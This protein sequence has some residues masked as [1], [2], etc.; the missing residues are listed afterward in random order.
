MEENNH[1][2]MEQYIK[3]RILEIPQ[4]E[5]RV[6]YKE[7]VGKLLL[8][9]YQYN[10]DSYN[11]LEERVLSESSS[12]QNN[13]AVY[14]TMTDQEHYDA[15]DT[16]MYPMSEEDVHK[17][18]I[19]VEEINAAVQKQEPLP[20]YT[21]YLQSHASNIY[22]LFQEERTFS[23]V[24]QTDKKEYKATFTVRRNETY[25]DMVKDLYYIFAA[26]N[27]PWT[28]VCEAY[29]TK[30]LDVYLCTAESIPDKEVIGDIKV[31]FEEYS[32][33]VR[34]GMIPLW[35]LMKI[36]EKTSTYPEPSIDKI[37]YEHQI[38]AHRLNRNCGY[39]VMNTEVEITNIRRVNGD[40]L[41]SCPVDKPCEWNLYQVNKKSGRE[42]Y[43][44]PI[45]GNLYKESFSGNI[46]EMYRRSIKTKG[47]MA[48]LMEAFS[49]DNYVRFIGMEIRE[50]FPKEWEYSNYNMDGFIQDE[51]RIG[52]G[53]WAL[54]L[55]F[56]PVEQ[57]NYLNEDIMSFL[58]T[59]V[60]KM[61]PE[62]FCIGRLNKEA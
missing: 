6:L 2:D 5:D 37:N 51:I 13:Y 31:D 23:G 59:Q 41:I 19:S 32:H 14:L 44:Y 53:R 35:N 55:N 56:V 20:V 3:K 54:V 57:D 50:T 36:S 52:S 61:F 62:Y 15:T 38:F 33:M 34:R 18:E 40:L 58:V 4:L 26:N 16:F 46:T 25:L 49:Y 30:M 12:E 27:Q 48:R 45:L 22:R 11:K 7:I 29:L 43:P 1:F 8:E 24:I 47:E 28:T 9:L 21:V 60:Q 42:H 17:K 10:K 39:L